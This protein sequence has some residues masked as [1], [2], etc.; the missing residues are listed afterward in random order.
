[1]MPRMWRQAETLDSRLDLAES[2]RMRIS[3]P[4]RLACLIAVL[5][6]LCTLGVSARQAQAPSDVKVIAKDFHQ[7]FLH[8]ACTGEY[9]PQPDTCLHKQL[10]EK[11]FTFGGPKGTVHQVH[12]RIRGLFEPTTITGGETPNAQHPYYQVG[13]TIRAREWS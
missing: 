11:A 4:G 7:L 8:D 3:K 5:A 6:A 1:M 12:L 10:V 2:R 13:G 9:P